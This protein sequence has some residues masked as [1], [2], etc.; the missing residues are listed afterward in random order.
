MVSNVLDMDEDELL[1]KVRAFKKKYAEDPE[2]KKLRA[3]LPK[4]WPI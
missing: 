4:D 3:D 1:K 2:Y